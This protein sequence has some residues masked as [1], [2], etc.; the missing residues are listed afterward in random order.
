MFI[1]NYNATVSSTVIVG[2]SVSAIGS[3]SVLFFL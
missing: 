1:D 2:F 3:E